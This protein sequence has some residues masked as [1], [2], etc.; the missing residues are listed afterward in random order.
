MVPIVPR[1]F[2]W[3]DKEDL[4][5]FFHLDEVNEEFYDVL[6]ELKDATQLGDIDEV[7]L[8]NEV[9]YQAT[10]IVF[11]RPMPDDL[12]RYILDIKGNVGKE[13][14]AE[15]VMT[16]VYHLLIL[17]RITDRPINKFYISLIRDKL[18]RSI[19][20]KPFKHCFEKLKKE[21]KHLSYTFKPCPYPANVIRYNCI[22]SW[23]VITNDY[24]LS[25][26]ET[27]MNLWEDI[28]EK[29]TLATMIESSMVRR[30][31]GKEYV[32]KK[33]QIHKFFLQYLNDCEMK[34]KQALKERELME[35]AKNKENA[36]EN[37]IKI[38]QDKLGNESVPLSVL[39][40][41]L[42][43]Y[44]EEAGLQE[45]HSVFNHLNT[46]LIDQPAWTK[47]VPELKNFFKEARKEKETRTITLTGS[48]AVYN[49]KVINYGS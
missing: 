23:D 46:L 13:I 6:C 44:A 36:L 30:F 5:D 41:G 11:E 15:L 18:Y 33:E 9:Y 22:I 14:S 28:R 10:R 7:K 25:Y 49:E 42:M 26:I 32:L 16:M 4:T 47:N 43:E 34:Q 20:W 35:E 21:G 38:L 2:L 24:E 19:Y 3:T 39:A 48:N 17:I 45:A 37:Q 8:F 27:V 12:P 29:Y 31:R 1:I 40:E